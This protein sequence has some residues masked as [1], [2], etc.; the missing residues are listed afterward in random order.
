MYDQAKWWSALLFE[1][2]LMWGPQ[3]YPEFFGDLAPWMFWIA[4]VLLPIT[5]LLLVLSYREKRASQRIAKF[6]ASDA[7]QKPMPDLPLPDFL[8]ET[9]RSTQSRKGLPKL[10][11][12]FREK[13]NLGQINV[14][15]RLNAVQ[16][17]ELG[18]PL[19]AIPSEFWQDHHIELLEL[20]A[21][22]PRSSTEVF[23]VGAHAAA[24]FS[25]IHV[26][27]SQV[28]AIWPLASEK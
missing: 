3:A 23:S 27:R 12:E 4:A 16:G 18:Y 28:S 21:D 7:E 20:F 13:A 26:N 22:P 2:A 6:D 1:A 9:L 14:W 5:F 25:D 24:H 10:L 19:T 8:S 11:A 17:H 15:G